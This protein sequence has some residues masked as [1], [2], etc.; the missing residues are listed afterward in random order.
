MLPRA[1]SLTRVLPPPLSLV[2]PAGYSVWTTTSSPPCLRPCSTGSR[3]FSKEGGGRGRETHHTHTHT[4]ARAQAPSACRWGHMP[5]PGVARAGRYAAT[6]IL[7]DA[8]APAPSL[9]CPPQVPRPGKQ[10]RVDLRAAH[11]STHCGHVILP[12]AEGHVS[13]KLLVHARPRCALPCELSRSS[14]SSWTLACCVRACVL[15]A[16]VL[17]YPL[18]TKLFL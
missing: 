5:A 2:S 6:R 14:V 17:T 13:G 12:R 18:S 9:S 11:A 3:T 10:P 16:S 7:T 15:C 8:R 4:Q 1:S